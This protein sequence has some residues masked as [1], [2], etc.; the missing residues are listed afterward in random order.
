M[1]ELSG[2]LFVNSVSDKN[3][4]KRYGGASLYGNS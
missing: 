2:T 3:T 1:N 4:K